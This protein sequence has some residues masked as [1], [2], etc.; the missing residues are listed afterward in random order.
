MSEPTVTYN[1]IFPPKSFVTGIRQDAGDTRPVVISG[2][3]PPASGGEPQALLYRGPLFPSDPAGYHHLI[4]VFAGQNVTASTFYGPNTPL[5]N[6]DIGAGQVRAVGSYKYSDT[7]EFDHGMMYEGKFDGSGVWTELNMPADLAGGTVANTLAHSTMGHLVVG[8]YDL[9]GQPGSANAFIYN[10][11]TKKYRRLSL[12]PLTTAYG[13]WQNGGSDSTA[14]T[15]VG[16]YKTGKGLNVGYLLNY[17]STTGAIS[18]LTDYSYDNQPGIVTHFEGITGVPV[19][20][21]GLQGGYTLAA[22]SDRGSAF[23]ALTRNADGS[24][25]TAR[26]VAIANPNATGVTTANSIL[27]N[28]LIGIYKSAS[29]VQSFVATVSLGL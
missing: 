4:P 7:G 5:F 25:G 1:D 2:N 20:G 13:I 10:I 3:S 6:P 17:D 15:I 9:K 8:N 24:F 12:G 29:G 16:G 28:E 11:K 19:V 14:Y 22:M 18:D 21:T 27:E 26:W 23:A